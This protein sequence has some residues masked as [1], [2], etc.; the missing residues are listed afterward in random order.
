MKTDQR[1]LEDSGVE[2][3]RKQ[4]RRSIITVHEETSE[5][6]GYFYYLDY[7]LVYGHTHIKT[8]HILYFNYVHF[9]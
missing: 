2:K 3:K 7:K 6:D 4:Q 9:L 8:Y 5:I 1:L